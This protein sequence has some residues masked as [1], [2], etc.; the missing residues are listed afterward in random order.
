MRICPVFFRCDVYVSVPLGRSYALSS[1]PAGMARKGQS[2][3]PFIFL[4]F[5]GRDRPPSSD[6][7]TITQLRA[8]RPST[9]SP[10]NRKLRKTAYEQDRRIFL[11]EQG[12]V[13][14]SDRVPSTFSPP[15]QR[16]GLKGPIFFP[17]RGRAPPCFFTWRVR[18][19]QLLLHHPSLPPVRRTGASLSV[20]VTSPLFLDH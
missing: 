3:S 8:V 10:D 15:L 19:T 17:D 12:G 16:A 7:C 11:F 13:P 6:L 5:A 18:G 14:R 4:E 1:E 2:F 9:S 20:T